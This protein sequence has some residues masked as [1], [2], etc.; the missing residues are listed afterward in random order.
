MPV[1][2]KLIVSVDAQSPMAL[3]SISAA[4]SVQ[5][6]APSAH[7]RFPGLASGVSFS[8]LTVNG[9]VT[10]GRSV[11]VNGAVLLGQLLALAFKVNVAL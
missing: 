10:Q 1:T 8:E 3:A 2:L 4:R 5:L 7:T 11:I 9:V 6:P